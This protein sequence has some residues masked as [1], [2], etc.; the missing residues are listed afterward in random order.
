MTGNPPL[1]GRLDVITGTQAASARNMT[2]STIML[3]IRMIYG[4]LTLIQALMPLLY[5]QVI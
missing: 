2:G 1:W 3:V 4:V 5:M